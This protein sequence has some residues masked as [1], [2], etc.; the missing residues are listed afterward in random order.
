MPDVPDWELHLDP[1]AFDERV[2]RDTNVAR[3]ARI[4]DVHALV[5]GAEAVVGDDD[6]V[7][8][9]RGDARRLR[10]TDEAIAGDGGVRI[11]ARKDGGAQPVARRFLEDVVLRIGVAA[12][13]AERETPAAE[14][15]SIDD[16]V[17]RGTIGVERPPR[18]VD[19]DLGGIAALPAVV[20]SRDDRNATL[21]GPWGEDDGLPGGRVGRHRTEVTGVGLDDVGRVLNM[22][23]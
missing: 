10:Q 15:E 19:D 1:V 12:A 23:R 4:V 14:G 5:A 11:A 22:R 6:V 2:A 21:I 3:I 7:D 16:D 8:A 9:P 18:V 17:R 20:H 13:V